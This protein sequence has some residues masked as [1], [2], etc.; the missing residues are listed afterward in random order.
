MRNLSVSIGLR[1]LQKRFFS[2]RGFVHAL[3]D[4]SLEIKPGELFVILGPSGSG[5]STVLN[6]IAGLEKPTRGSVFFDSQVV[7]SEKERV[8]LEPF[9]RDVAMVFQNYALYPHMTVYH[10]IAF[11]LT[12]LKMKRDEIRRKVLAAAGLLRISHLL[13]RRPAELSGGERQR[14]AIGRAIV[15]TPKVLLMDEPLS[16]LDARLRMDMRAEIKL[17]IKEIGI[18]TVYVT[19][20]QTEAMALADRI[21]VLR[22]G[23]L[24][25][26]GTPHQLFH[27][28]SHLF[29]ASFVGSP[30]MNFIK[31]RVEGEYLVNE[32][33]RVPLGDIIS[34]LAKGRDLRELTLGIRPQDIV[35]RSKNGGTV[36]V[37]VQVTETVGD[38]SLIYAYADQQKFVVEVPSVISE[39]E[40]SLE[41][42]KEKVH[43]FDP[44][45]FR[46]EQG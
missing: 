46:V 28:P 19:H 27:Q 26:I 23:S 5:K 21:A 18:T 4:L 39:K 20:D 24:Q 45:G 31:G 17:L 41:W 14:V 7:A 36:N 38:H 30:P 25:Q 22:E 9:E 11:P 8:F 29:V 10:N 32:S 1:A 40:V 13:E 34:R 16:N 44:E 43:V 12:N 6:L 42:P 15:R 37:L 35:V 3:E 33:V 2:L